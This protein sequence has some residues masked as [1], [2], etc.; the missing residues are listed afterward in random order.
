[1]TEEVIDKQITE[2]E[3]RLNDHA[4][5]LREIEKTQAVLNNQVL[6]LCKSLDATNS[7]MKA[8]IVAIATSLA[9]FFIYA[10]QAG[11]FK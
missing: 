1:M 9:G 2:H 6:Q 3:D 11:I 4:E 10:I 7:T 8:L 5:R